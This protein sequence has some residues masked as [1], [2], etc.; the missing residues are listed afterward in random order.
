MASACTFEVPSVPNFPLPLITESKTVSEQSQ[1]E[2]LPKPAEATLTDEECNG[3]LLHW[4]ADIRRAARAAANR[5]QLD[6]SHADDFAQEARI[7]LLNAVRRQPS[8]PEKYLRKVI[9]NAIQTAVT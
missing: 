9:S 2:S 5:F 1:S 6:E 3:V 7:R 8:L 4:D